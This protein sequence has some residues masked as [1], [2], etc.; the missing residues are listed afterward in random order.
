MSTTVSFVIYEQFILHLDDVNYLS[1]LQIVIAYM[2]ADY[3]NKAPDVKDER[4]YPTSNLILGMKSYP[5]P[6]KF[7]DSGIT[8]VG[9]LSDREYSPASHIPDSIEPLS[10]QFWSAG[11]FGSDQE[12]RTVPQCSIYTIN[13]YFF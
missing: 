8:S 2:V 9:S 10:R 7:D 1:V 5:Q 12:R 6:P 11:D 3:P 13:C 4:P